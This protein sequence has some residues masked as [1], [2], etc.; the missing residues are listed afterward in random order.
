[1]ELTLTQ[2]ELEVLRKLVPH[3][4]LIPGGGDIGEDYNLTEDDDNALWSF[5][6]KLQA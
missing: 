2:A 6:K 5:I 1:M 3:L 4:E